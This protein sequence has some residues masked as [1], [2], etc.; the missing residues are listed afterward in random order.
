VIAPPGLLVRV[1]VWPTPFCTVEALYPGAVTLE[2]ASGADPLAL[3]VFD[4]LFVASV[5]VALA[6]I[7]LC[8]APN[9]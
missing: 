6:V 5:Y 7:R 8:P 1:T 9:N 3:Y 4:T 2:A